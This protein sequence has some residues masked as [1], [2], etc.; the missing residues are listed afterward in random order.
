MGEFGEDAGV[1][2][3]R[4]VEDEGIDQGLHLTRELLEHQMLV[5]HLGGEARRLEQPLAVPV[6][7]VGEGGLIQSRQG[8]EVGGKPPDVRRQPFIDEGHVARAQDGQ[9]LGLDLPVVFRVEDVVDGGQ[10]DVLI[11]AS[12]AGGEVGV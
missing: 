3:G 9:L 12:V 7:R 5:L 4:A 6:Q 11:A 10:A 1:D 2:V 8:G